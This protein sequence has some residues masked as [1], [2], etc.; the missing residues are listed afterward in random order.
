MTAVISPAIV[1]TVTRNQEILKYYKANPENI[2]MEKACQIN[3]LFNTSDL[4]LKK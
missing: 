3:Y 1:F 2:V 4:I